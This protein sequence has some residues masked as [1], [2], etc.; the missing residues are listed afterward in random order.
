MNTTLLVEPMAK[1]K[2]VGRPVVEIRREQIVNLKG[3]PEFKEWLRRFADHAGL[4]IADTVGMALKAY[5]EAEGFETPPK[6]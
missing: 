4:S 1:K 6:R 5:A 3:R 2:P